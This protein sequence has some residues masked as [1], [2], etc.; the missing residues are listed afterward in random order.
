MQASSILKGDG[1]L[2]EEIDEQGEV[3]GETL[4]KN[5]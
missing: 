2:D 4:E 1:E 5:L 3:N